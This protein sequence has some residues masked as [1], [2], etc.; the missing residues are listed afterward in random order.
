M[1]MRAALMKADF[2]SLRGPLQFSPNG[3]PIQN[4]YL[5]KVAK[6]PDGKYQTEI[7]QTIYKDF[8]DDYAKD[9]PLH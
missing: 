8:A 6:R 1:G 7:V 9:C 3:F 2:K 4:F 5:T